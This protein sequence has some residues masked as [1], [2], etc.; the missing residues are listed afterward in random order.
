M[1]GKGSTYLSELTTA[2]KEL[3]GHKYLG[4]YPSDKIPQMNDGDMLIANLDNSTGP[5]SHWIAI[6]QHKNKKLIYDSFGR[7]TSEIM[8]NINSSLDTEHD[9]EQNVME[10][11]C[12][13]RSLTALAVYKN[14]G[15]KAYL[16]L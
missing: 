4:T 11:N 7:K 3:F 9:A 13:A 6:V 14:W 16:Q 2:G 8:P 12:G 1:V 10:E 5:G 15:K